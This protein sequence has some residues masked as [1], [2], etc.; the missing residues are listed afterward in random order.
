MND[1]QQEFPELYKL[2][3]RPRAFFVELFYSM[4]KG[5]RLFILSG[6]LLLII[7]VFCHSIINYTIYGAEPLTDIDIYSGNMVQ[8]IWRTGRNILLGLLLADFTMISVS[9]IVQVTRNRFA[10]SI[11]IT[12]EYFWVVMLVVFSYR[13]ALIAA[14]FIIDASKLPV[15]P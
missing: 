5:L 9:S 2:K 13:V 8:I 12:W 1:W 11:K 6:A 15:A 7:Y 14:N 4:E 3:S 10:R